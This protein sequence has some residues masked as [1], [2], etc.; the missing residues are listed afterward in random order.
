M[1]SLVYHNGRFWRLDDNDRIPRPSQE[2]MDKVEEIAKICQNLIF[3][4]CG[5]QGTSY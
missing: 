4:K 2:L 5:I 3:W 1:K